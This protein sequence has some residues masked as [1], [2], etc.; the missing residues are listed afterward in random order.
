[1]GAPVKGLIGRIHRSGDLEAFQE[2]VGRYDGGMKLVSRLIALMGFLGLL[3]LPLP[4]AS[5]A[6]QGKAADVPKAGLELAKMA[7]QVT[8][9]A[10]SPLLGVSAIGAYQ[11]SEAHTEKEKAA[12]P[13]FAH[14]LFWLPCML[15]VAACAFKDGFGTMIPPG[16]K[17]PFDVLETIENKLTGLV[18]AGAVV[19]I[20]V[21]SASKLMTHGSPVAGLGG[22]DHFGGLAMIHLGA[23]DFSWLLDVLLVPLAITVFAIVWLAS[24]AINV[25]ILLS[26]WGGVDAAL[27]AARTSL[28]GLLTATAMIDPK[29]GAALSLVILVVAYFIA[30]WSF[31]LTV[32]GSIF[33]WDFFTRRRKRFALLADGN[34]VFTGCKINRVPIRTYGRLYQTEG[35]GLVLKF[36]PWLVLPLRELAVPPNGLVVGC[37]VF[38]SEL[39]GAGADAGDV[40]P[41]L[42]LPPRYL[43]HEQAF[44]QKY[45]VR[46]LREIGLLRVWSWL[47]EAL[48]LRPKKDAM[49]PGGGIPV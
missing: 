42:L 45:G 1:V 7:T 49:V 4:A 38:Y 8:G 5:S 12:L 40:R 41:L 22:L 9:I 20:L 33:C 39:L 46:S 2:M 17:K 26:P 28:L 13:W 14:P 25:L 24:H 47:R 23:I 44:A 29:V 3:T 16:L 35:G 18:A 15:L 10:I 21:N 36:R 37:G 34:K 27:K 30:G 32:F 31:R 6:D 19:P 11:W 48:G 43:G